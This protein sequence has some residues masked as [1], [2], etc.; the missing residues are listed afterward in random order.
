MKKIEINVSESLM[1]LCE[2]AKASGHVIYIVGGFVRNQVLGYKALDCDIAGSLKPDELVALCKSLKMQTNVMSNRLGT[3]IIRCNQESFEYT[4]FREEYYN[5]GGEHVP[6]LVKFVNDIALDARR[7]DFSC[8]A[9]YYNPLTTDFFDPYNGMEDTKAGILKCIE[10]PLVVF[11]SDGLRILRFIK[12]LLELDFVADKNSYKTA[13]KLV[14]QLNDISKERIS[15]ELDLIVNAESKYF[16]GQINC[17]ISGR[18][19]STPTNLTNIKVDNDKQGQVRRSVELLNEFGIYHYI[20]NSTFKGL[21]IKASGGAFRAYLQTGQNIR[22]YAFFVLALFNKL[23]QKSATQAQIKM[24][25][26]AMLGANGLKQSNQA[27]KAVVNFYSLFNQ[28]SFVKIKNADKDLPS[29]KTNNEVE[30]RKASVVSDKKIELKTKSIGIAEAVVDNKDSKRLQ[31]NLDVVSIGKAVNATEFSNE[32]FQGRL[33]AIG[34]AS[35]PQPVRQFLKNADAKKFEKIEEIIA[36][37]KDRKCPFSE[38]EL[39]ITNQQLLDA[40]VLPLVISATR[41]QLFELCVSGNLN[42]TTEE[43]LNALS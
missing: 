36:Q 20:F 25:V 9:I 21:K 14:F 5:S 29:C 18:P 8:N 24:E 4:T 22:L 34:I 31:N 37:L 13:K 41:M 28:F 32:V 15:R 39:A 3:V 30:E 26:N 27:I 11:N 7:R 17:E 42:N 1:R 2:A 35:A 10:S 33:L 40:G 43:L 16:N 12:F 23:K 38:K 19:W 6:S